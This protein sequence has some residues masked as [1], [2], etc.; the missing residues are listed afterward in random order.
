VSR[1]GALLFEIIVSAVRSVAV[2]PRYE[3]GRQ[4]IKSR[5]HANAGTGRSHPPMRAHQCGKSAWLLH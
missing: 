3:T 2:Q 5:K 4:A 1:F